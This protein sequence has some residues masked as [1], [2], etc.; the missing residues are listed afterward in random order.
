MYPGN[1]SQWG[2][3]PDETQA[4]RFKQID[5][6]RQY[7]PTVK[8][9]AKESLYEIPITLPRTRQTV[10]LRVSLSREFPRQPP[11]L[12]VLPP[13][14]HAI[15]DSQ[16]FVLASAHENLAKWTVH[17]SLGKTV[18]EVVQKFMK[19]PPHILQQSSIAATPAPQPTFSNTASS[20]PPPPYGQ[21]Q[22]ITAVPQ[23]T[24]APAP[25][26]KQAVTGSYQ[27]SNTASTHTPLPV[28][29][30]SFPELEAKTPSELSQLLNDEQ[31]FKKFF[32]ALAIVQTMKKVRD[33]L[34]SNN[35]DLAKRNLSRE[36]EVETLKREL[37]TR[38]QIVSEKRTSFDA[39]F[40]RQQEI[41]K[42]YSTPA[43]I[44][45]LGAAAAEAEASSDVLANQFVSGGMDYKDFVKEFLDKRKLYHLRSAKKESLSMM[46]RQ[47]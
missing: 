28:I 10:T 11:T 3:R 17:A 20:K 30:S 13:V 31:E 36:A 40:Q 24:P 18:Y 38:H 27:S 37:A 29:P 33:D 12:Q 41:M 43:L 47:P 16:M 45:Q 32:D 22:P 15:V 14:Q 8:E 6:L 34:R 19:E 2:A 46:A 21:Q 35:E 42:Q 23:P 5:S 4:L 1:Q 39:K 25:V 7:F 26:P 44:A 9:I